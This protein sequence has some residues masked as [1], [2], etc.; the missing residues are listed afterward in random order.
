MKFTQKQCDFFGDILNS[1]HSD[2]E[3]ASDKIDFKALWCKLDANEGESINDDEFEWLTSRIDAQIELERLSNKRNVH[4]R[5]E[6]RSLVNAKN[7][8]NKLLTPKY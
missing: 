7:K 4:K 8:V 5:G 3:L 2:V 6:I 1:P